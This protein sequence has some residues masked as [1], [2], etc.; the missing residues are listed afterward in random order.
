MDDDGD[1]QPIPVVSSSPGTPRVEITELLLSV[2]ELIADILEQEQ[3][4]YM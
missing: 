1:G 2:S 3:F 4:V